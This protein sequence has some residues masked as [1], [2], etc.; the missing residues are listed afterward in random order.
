MK[1]KLNFIVKKCLRDGNVNEK[2][3]DKN[4]IFDTPKVKEC[5]LLLLPLHI[6]FIYL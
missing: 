5:L 1:V 3:D 4:N 6:F 2:E